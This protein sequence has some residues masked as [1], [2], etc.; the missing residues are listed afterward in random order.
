[1]LTKRVSEN[2]LRR[3]FNEGRYYERMLAGEFKAIIVSEI[4]RRRGDRRIRGSRS[5]F[6]EYWDK[7]GV[8]IARVHQYRKKDGS[9]GASGRPDPKRLRRE[10]VLYQLDTSEDWDIPNW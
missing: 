5:Q 4:P 10:G 9:L 6:V 2:E 3:L 8:L 7:S 1:M